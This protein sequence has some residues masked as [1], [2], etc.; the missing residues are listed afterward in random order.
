MPIVVD[1]GYV[2]VQRAELERLESVESTYHA[3]R[4]GVE[5]A[6]KPG[7]ERPTKTMLRN[8]LDVTE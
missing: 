8:L 6:A 1:D 5:L 7:P 3:L 2:T 4:A